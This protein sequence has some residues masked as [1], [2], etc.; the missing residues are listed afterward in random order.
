MRT[1]GRRGFGRGSDDLR[2]FVLYGST[3]SGCTCFVDDISGVKVNRDLSSI[4]TTGSTIIANVPITLYPTENSSPYMHIS[5]YIH[6]RS[7]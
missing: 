3:V 4:G 2:T 1:R 5:K 7:Q 6:P